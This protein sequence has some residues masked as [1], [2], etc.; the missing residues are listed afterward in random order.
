MIPVRGNYLQAS[1]DGSMAVVGIEVPSSYITKSSVPC[2]LWNIVG[3]KCNH[4]A[5]S[6]ARMMRIPQAIN[7]SLAHAGWFSTVN[8]WNMVRHPLDKL[9]QCL[10]LGSLWAGL[11]IL[12]LELPGISREKKCF[13]PAQWEHIWLLQAV[14]AIPF[15]LYA[16]SMP[17]LD[18]PRYLNHF[19]PLGLSR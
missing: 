15:P 17:T 13:Q 8:R 4:D 11:W 18:I 14:E 5:P 2:P 16:V 19:V 1:G 10:M 6:I 7:V 9:L 12:L 3:E